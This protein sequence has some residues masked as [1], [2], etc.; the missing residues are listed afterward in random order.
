MA[1]REIEESELL[2]K[3]RVVG[4]YNRML[5]NPKS[6]E[7]LERAYKTVEP[8]ASSPITDAKDEV[9]SEVIKER[10]ARIALEARLDKEKE[11]RDAEKARSSFASEWDRQKSRLR[12]QG[13][14]DE[15]IA[16]VEKLC[17]E[18]GIADLEAGAA[19]HD[20]LH[21]PAEPVTPN[22][23]GHWNLFEPAS[24]DGE[25]FKKL[26]DSKGEDDMALRKM[27]DGALTDMRGGVRR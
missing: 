12:S 4:V 7:L 11:E 14:T 6:R 23:F 9:M 24:R 22:G 13:Y 15:G 25:D 2:A 16:S 5:A 3:E 19:L 17:E 21:P 26:L 27:V 20:R 18:R 8:N 10:E 1:T